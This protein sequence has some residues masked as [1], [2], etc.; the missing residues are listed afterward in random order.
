MSKAKAKKGEVEVEIKKEPVGPAVVVKTDMADDMLAK[1]IAIVQEAISNN[2]MEKDMTN[3]VK[4][5]MDI[6][7]SAHEFA[8]FI[9]FF[10]SKLSSSL[11][12]PWIQMM[13]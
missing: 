3:A 6:V 12:Q 1:T 13:D 2:K 4:S 10:F 11:D 5:K 9:C 8:L 7:R